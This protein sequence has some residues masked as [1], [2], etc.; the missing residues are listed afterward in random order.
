LLCIKDEKALI[1]PCEGLSIVKYYLFSQFSFGCCDEKTRSLS[2]NNS[3]QK[4]RFWTQFSGTFVQVRRD[5]LAVKERLLL[6]HHE[7]RSEQWHA[8]HVFIGVFRRS[9]IY[10][11]FLTYRHA[12]R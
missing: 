12:D 11:L 8:Q 9:D 4:R 1:L 6:E 3:A 7:R 2:P 5:D 10:A